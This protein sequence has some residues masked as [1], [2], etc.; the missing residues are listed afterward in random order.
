MKLKVW[1]Q[2]ILLLMRH[3]MDLELCDTQKEFLESINF[4]PSN[5]RQVK[6]GS[7]SFTI[8]QIHAAAVKYKINVNWIFGLDNEMRFKKSADTL[9]QLK[10]TIRTLE[11]TLKRDKIII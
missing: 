10:D 8:E 1:D 4:Q 3:C 2:R 6:N 11:A 7:Q 9:T 5:L